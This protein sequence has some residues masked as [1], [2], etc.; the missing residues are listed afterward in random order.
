METHSWEASLSN[1]SCL[2]SRKGIYYKRNEFLEKTPFRR[3]LVCSTC[4]RKV[5]KTISLLKLRKIFQMFPSRFNRCPVYYRQTLTHLVSSGLFYFNSLVFI[6]TMFY[7]NPYF[8]FNAN[9][10]DPDQTPRS[11]QTGLG[12][13]ISTNTFRHIPGHYENKPIQIY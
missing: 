5:A 11:A 1:N 4:K 3:D 2:P 7:R 12:L 10:I 8:I 13:Y 9:G 6:F